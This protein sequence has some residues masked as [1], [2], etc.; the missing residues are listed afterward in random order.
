M[1]KSKKTAKSMDVLDEKAKPLNILYL[2]IQALLMLLNE[3]V[4]L[5][6][7]NLSHVLFLIYII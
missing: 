5:E 3:K 7:S 1:L 6:Y 4:N 2:R